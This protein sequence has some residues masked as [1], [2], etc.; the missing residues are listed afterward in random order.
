MARTPSS[1]QT[2]GAGVLFS[3]DT[4]SRSPLV[5]LLR[6]AATRGPHLPTAA[7][8]SRRFLLLIMTPKPA[9][10]PPPLPARSR[11]GFRVAI[12]TA[13]VL[14]SGALPLPADGGRCAA[15]KRDIRRN[16]A[17]Y[18]LMQTCQPGSALNRKDWR[19]FRTAGL[20]VAANGRA[21]SGRRPGRHGLPA[22]TRNK[23]VLPPRPAA[24]RLIM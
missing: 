16:S 18:S 1:R 19:R 11:G 10:L 2:H 24:A 4:S 23:T 9:C 15:H 3:P 13:S 22:L 17:R 6:L 14:R 21:S 5:Q 12:K 7:M 20:S 8:S